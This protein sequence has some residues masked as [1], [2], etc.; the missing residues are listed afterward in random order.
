MIINH[1]LSALN[2]QRLQ[3]IN[4]AAASKGIAHL[5]SGS[6]INRAA[7]DAAGLAISEKMRAYVSGLNRASRNIQ[8]GVSFIQATEGYLSETTS[9][10]QRLRVLA[11]QSAN[12]IYQQEDRNQITV[13]VSQ[14]VAEVNRIA[15]QGQFNGINML[16]GS[17]AGAGG[18][19]QPAVAAAAASGQV[20]PV[21]QNGGNGGLVVH[22]GSNADQ[23]LNI[24]I[25]D[26]GASSLGIDTVDL[27]SSDGANT[28]LGQLDN[29]LQI[30]NK[31]R[32]D[33]GAYQNRLSQ[34]RNGVDLAAE[35]LQSAESRIRDA[36]MSSEVV[37]FTR[38]QIKSQAA[39]AMLAQ[40]NQR[41]QQI[42]QLLR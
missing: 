32:A 29:A 37:N 36:D 9:I 30:V 1:N 22:M 33:L 20:A 3:G 17:F 8:D 34:A 23:F 13:E 35:N 10:I 28:A 6:R 2:T 18:A 41:P 11:V 27:S 38:E 4:D 25:G 31:Q 16:D 21:V 15:S 7:D 24:A 42:L 40:A 14:L 26:M 39:T 5:S 12:G 19:Q